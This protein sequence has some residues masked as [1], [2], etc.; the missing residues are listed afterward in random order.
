M[1]RS[2]DAAP[3]APAGSLTSRPE[4]RADRARRLVYRGR[5]AML[6]ILLAVVA[7]AAIGGLVVL[8][9]RD[10]PAPSEAWSEW[11]PVGGV[12][13]RAVQIADHVSDPYRLPS[14]KQLATVT[15]AGPPTIASPDG[16][17]LQVR[18]LAVEAAATAPDAD[19]IDTF[20]ANSNVMYILC[21]LGDACSIPEGQTT[22]RP[23]RPSQ[24]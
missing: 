14:G 5:F 12:E 16:S 18:A 4:S 21:G 19:D 7:G 23:R 15:Y 11:E 24:A 8:L 17:T 6:Y 10:G 22:A 13:R 3:P 9:E 1:R 2:A 20:G